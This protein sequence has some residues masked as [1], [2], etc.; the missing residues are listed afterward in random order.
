M[1]PDKAKACA[2]AAAAGKWHEA[3]ELAKLAGIDHTPYAEKALIQVAQQPLRIWSKRKQPFTEVS[4][5][6]S[7]QR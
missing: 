4:R 1:E 2:D 5:R 3:A 7:P 6:T